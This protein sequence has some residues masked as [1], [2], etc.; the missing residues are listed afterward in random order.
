MEIQLMF[1]LLF[2]EYLIYIFFNMK[3]SNQNHH[4]K[5]EEIE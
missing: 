2:K 1:Q 4:L 5:M 3:I